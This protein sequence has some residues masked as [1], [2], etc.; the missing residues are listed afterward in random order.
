[1]LPTVTLTAV[2]VD[3]SAERGVSWKAVALPVEHGAWGLLVEPILLGLCLAPS[4]AG[5]AIAVAA[6]GAFLA[7]HPLK[8]VLADRGRGLRY[9]RTEA[10][11]RVALLYF[12]MTLLGLGAAADVPPLAFAP[13]VLAVPF[14]LAQLFYD[15][16]R[17]GRSVAA[18]VMGALALGCVA[19]AILISAGWP[20]G[21]ALAAWTL[22]ALKALAS[23]LYVR[24]RLRLD[25]GLHP[26]LAPALVSHGFAVLVASAM[27][28]RGLAPYLAVLA[29][30][31]L[32]VRAGFGLSRHHRVVRPRVVGLQELGFGLGFTWL[33][34]L[35]YALGW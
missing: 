3:A 26:G 24:A 32:S 20:V 35:G 13:L 9:P 34:I 11:E 17:A 18:E 5:F 16:R 23:I 7:R 1:M 6:L 22:L 19:A 31:V 29:F 10:A 2:P 12:L 8:L 14:G 30:I 25:R 21:V 15:V 28:G 4:R 33:L 27:A